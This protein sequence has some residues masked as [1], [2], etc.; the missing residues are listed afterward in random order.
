MT[1]LRTMM[2]GLGLLAASILPVQAG[3][4]AADL[5]T[6]AVKASG[7]EQGLA[8]VLGE[9]D[10]ALTAALAKGSRLYVQGCTW[11]AGSVAAARGALIAA[12]VADRASIVWVE[13]DGLPY[14][15]NLVNLIVAG[16]GAGRGVTAAEILRVLAPGGLAMVRADLEAGAKAAGARDVK[17]AAVP[18]W[19]QFGKNVDPAF[20]VWTHNNGGAD[21]SFVNSDKAAGPWTELRWIGEPRWGALRMIY[22]GRVSSG[23]RMYY[24]EY[25]TAP[26]GGTDV[27]LVG[28]DAWNGT[29]LWRLVIG[30]PPKYGSVGN[31][32]T[33]DETRVFCVENNAVLTARDGK[34]GKKLLEYSPGFVPTVA[35]TA[36]PAL[37]V[38]NLGISPPVANKVAA[39]DKDSGKVLWSRPGVCQPA[40]EN[41]TAFVLGASELEGVDLAS[42]ASRW[43][44]KTE[45]AP[46]SA[47]LFCKGGVVYATYSQPWKPVGLLVAHDA[48]TGAL[49]WKQESPRISYG[50]YPY[51][52]ELW[53]MQG[54]EKSTR[55]LQVLDPRTGTKKRDLA[56]KTAVNSHCFP[57]KGAGDYL[58]FSNAWTLNLK[59]GDAS[60][61]NT[62]RS[63]CDIGQMPA[64]GLTYFLPQHCSCGVT[65]RGL[66]AMSRAGARK[67]PAEGG[68]GAPQLFTS[69]AAPAAAAEGPEDWPFYRKDAARSNLATTKLPTELKP[70][71]TEKVGASRLT[72]AV[73]AYGVLCVAEPKTHRVFGRDAA[74]GKELWSFAADGRTDWAPAL[75]RGLCIFSTGAG[76]V[77][78]LDARTGKEVWRLRAAPAQ[79]FIGEEGQFASPWPV[80]GGV[81]P[82]NGEIFFSCGRSAGSDGGMWLLAADAATGKVRWR[83]KAGSSGDLVLSNGKELMM[84]R[85]Y[86]NMANGARVGGGKEPPGLLRTTP[87]L[88]YLSVMDYMATVEPL[89]SHQKH[90]E[91]TDGRITGEALAFSEKLGVA[92]WRYRF[93]VPKEMMKKEKADQRFIYARADGKNL[94]LLDEGIKQQMVGAVLAGETAYLAGVPASLD[95]KEKGELWV[96]SG[97]DGKKL[98]TLTL[99]VKPVYDGLSAAGGKLYLAAED[100]TLTCFGAK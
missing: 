34:T 40:A 38:C 92:A 4:P 78:A 88:T 15:D 87:Y 33:C 44:V 57:G 69:G 75:T 23:G 5:A 14:A 22:H 25:R 76:S 29:E 56:I 90:E 81:L 58:I 73:A 28:R 55:S 45:V 16:P 72:Q 26:G 80:V 31:T 70:L 99:D 35:A 21:Q 100:G 51:A 71:W 67:F 85:V 77:Y 52:E 64:N 74:S 47:R 83:A 12:G 68:D 17:A 50:I 96:L 82:Q 8:L 41:G 79:K 1:P 7:H 19:V 2:F 98:Q 18:G 32:I 13:G 65:L 11:E 97:T 20:D 62:V 95:P 43:K 27:W 48:K 36:G 59:T 66:V 60:N 37:L 10:G 84:T 46:G 61:Q 54:E 91:L 53:M 63:P 3:E 94:W 93:G 9:T 42:G 89:L 24:D 30:P 39:L 86:Y 6:Q 49:L